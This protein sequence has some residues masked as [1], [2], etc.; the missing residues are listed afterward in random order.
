MARA[1]VRWS[2]SHEGNNQ[3]GNAVAARLREGGFVRVGTA[4]YEAPLTRAEPYC[5]QPSA[6]R[7]Q[8]LE[9]RPGG[10]P[11][12][13]VWTYVDDPRVELDRAYTAV[14]VSPRSAATSR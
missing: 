7:Y 12:D 5:S 2:V 11:L 10:G 13:N 8:I 4:C 3:T 14:L 9:D 1:I 6:M